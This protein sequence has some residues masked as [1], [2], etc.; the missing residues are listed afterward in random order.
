MEFVEGPSLKTTIRDKGPLAL[1][2]ILR[3]GQQICSAL[4]AAHEAGMIHRDIKPDNIVLVPLPMGGESVKVLDFGIAKLKEGKSVE[5][6]LTL[7]GTGRGDRDPA[8]YVTRTGNGK[9]R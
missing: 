3:V 8:V 2:R 5:G 7:T 1:D 4:G 6:G 9:T